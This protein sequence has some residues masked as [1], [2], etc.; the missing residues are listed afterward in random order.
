LVVGQKPIIYPVKRE[1]HDFESCGKRDQKQ[2]GLSPEGNLTRVRISGAGQ[3][4]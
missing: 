2:R 1:G 3:I 4:L